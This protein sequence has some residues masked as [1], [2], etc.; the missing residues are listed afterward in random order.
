MYLWIQP[1]DSDNNLQSNREQMLSAK[2]EHFKQYHNQRK[3]TRKLLNYFF[4]RK[5]EFYKFVWEYSLRQAL[6]P[7]YMNMK[8]RKKL[9]FRNFSQISGQIIYIPF[10]PFGYL[11][12]LALKHWWT[13]H[14]KIICI[15]KSS[16]D[17]EV[18]PT[19]EM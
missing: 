12:F 5:M 13:V 10:H 3:P 19:E 17:Q 1:K 6:S 8:N 14:P 11:K 9:R 18:A 2:Y 7:I 15:N 16:R 4:H